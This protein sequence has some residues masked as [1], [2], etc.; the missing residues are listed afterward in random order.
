M[1]KNA[2]KTKKENI[3]TKN[4]STE[5]AS[6]SLSGV[7]TTEYDIVSAGTTPLKLAGILKNAIAGDATEYLTLA[8]EMEE[9]DAHYRAVLSVRKETLASLTPTLKIASEDNKKLLE[10]VEDLRILINT[11]AFGGL[12]FDLVDGLAKGYSVC[13][14]LWGT[15]NS[16][17]VPQEYVWRD[18]RFFQQDKLSE[19]L[20]L[21]DDNI[22]EGVELPPYKFIQFRPKLKSGKA[23]RGGLAFIAC[24]SYIFKSF[25]LKDWLS[26]TEAYGMPLR[27]GKYGAGASEEDK[28]VLLRAVSSIGAD[29][30]AI[31]PESMQIEFVN[32][33]SSTGD[34]IFINLANWLDAQ[35]SKAILGQTMT[36]DNGSSRSQSE[37]H[38]KVRKDIL[39]GDA[40]ELSNAINKYL[41]IPYINLN[42]GV[43]EEYPTFSLVQEK[44]EDVTALVENVAKLVPLGLTVNQ[45]EM[46]SKLGLKEP[47]E[48]EKVLS[49]TPP[50]SMALNS[51]Q[52][53]F[54]DHLNGVRNK[55]LNNKESI[56]KIEKETEKER[57][58]ELEIAHLEDELNAGWKK[59][60]EPLVTPI[61]ELVKDCK[62]LQELLERLPELAEKVNASEL[63]RA[64]AESSFK[65]QALE[66]S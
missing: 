23:I 12:L 54:K 5:Q 46:L 24:W 34:A 21:R 53:V 42:Y 52:S 50:E 51:V 56:N 31:I 35:V 57:D 4:L 55:A 3:N 30:G 22:K 17:W 59:V 36:T 13:E 40:R 28:R 63:M 44:K 37:T 10:I 61:E 29:M 8:E 6:P 66:N 1:G 25:T 15:T 16:K 62:S 48:G 47:K 14:I 9:R 49:Y 2:K 39:K 64:I 41:L 65:A 7:R 20:K 27:L 38:D 43:Q 45:L 58:I 11:P 32:G 33:N 60:A 18:P 26:F 19:C